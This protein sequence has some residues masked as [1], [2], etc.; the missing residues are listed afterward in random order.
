MKEIFKSRK[1][2]LFIISMI[3]VILLAVFKQDYQGVIALYVAYC[4][5]N[6]ATKVAHKDSRKGD[7]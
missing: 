5:G 3:A 7:Q 1:V 2:I 4:T 6:V